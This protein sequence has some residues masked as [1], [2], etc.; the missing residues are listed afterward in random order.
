VE[1]TRFLWDE[2]QEEVQEIAEVLARRSGKTICEVWEE[3]LDLHSVKYE[4]EVLL[5]EERSS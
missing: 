2:L 3:A 4:I 1:E 5:P